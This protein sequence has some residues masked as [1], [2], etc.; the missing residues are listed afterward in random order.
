MFRITISDNQR[1]VLVKDGKM[2]R[3]LEPGRH[4]FFT[5]GAELSAVV[6]DL[7]AGFTALTPELARVLPAGS[8]DE[9]V[10]ERGELAMLGV[11]GLP[12]AV[13][14]RKSTRLNSSH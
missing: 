4:R 1:A 2:T 10:V 7:D 9:L 6:F 3:F 13:L 8:F 12:K 14:D 5:F 11:D